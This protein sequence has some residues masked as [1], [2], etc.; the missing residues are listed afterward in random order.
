M[1]SCMDTDHYG[2]TD[3]GSHFGC[4]FYGAEP[5]AKRRKGGA[6]TDRLKDVEERPYLWV[7]RISHL[8][9]SGTTDEKTATVMA[10]E[11]GQA[12]QP[13]YHHPAS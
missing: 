10:K 7:W 3:G 1:T 6:V 13:L 4:R 9:W 5:E 11:Y 12:P 8:T 2:P